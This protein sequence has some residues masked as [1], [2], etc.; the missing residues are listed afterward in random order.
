MLSGL[1]PHDLVLR[2]RPRT[3]FIFHI[4]YF[5]VDCIHFTLPF[6]DLCC[7]TDSKRQ[8]GFN[9][10]VATVAPLAAREAVSDSVCRGSVVGARTII[11]QL[12]QLKSVT[13]V[14]TVCRAQ[15]YGRESKAAVVCV[16]YVTHCVTQTLPVRNAERKVAVSLWAR[17]IAKHVI[18]PT[19]SRCARARA[20]HAS[21]LFDCL[22]TSPEHMIEPWPTPDLA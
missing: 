13:S 21:D 6:S 9:S 22:R 1:V 3:G 8:E 12:D 7:E 14:T 11:L 16:R 15:V 17:P 19:T 18:Q 4:L 10:S 5:L 20:P 2:C